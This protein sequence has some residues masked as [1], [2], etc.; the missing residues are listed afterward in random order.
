M[1]EPLSTSALHGMGHRRTLMKTGALAMIGIATRSSLVHAGDNGEISHA[2]ESIHQERFFAT[3]RKRIYQALTDEK[4]FNKIVE[5]SGVMK[6]DANGKMQ[7]PTQLSAQEGGTFVLFN[8]F[9][10]GRQI[11]LTP[12]ELIVQAWRV[13]NW[14][15]GRYSI[16]RFELADHDGGTKLVFDH[17]GIP[18]GSAEHLASG[19]QEHYWDPLTKLLV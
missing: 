9:I 4:Q 1:R 10:V 14:P 12:D 18:A 7:N 6:A 19:W 16:A 3:S 17:T 11:E 13:V 2:E 5:L 8:G 15:K